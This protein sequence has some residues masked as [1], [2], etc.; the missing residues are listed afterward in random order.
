VFTGNLNKRNVHSSSTIDWMSPNY[1][2]DS[3]INTL[4]TRNVEFERTG[5][6]LNAK[7]VF[8]DKSELLADI[9]FINFGIDG[10]QL[11]RTQ[12][13]A[14]GSPVQITKGIIPSDLEILTAKIDYSR[15]FNNFFWEAGIKTASTKTD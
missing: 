9:D 4:G 1:E 2:I 14:M 15:R 10:D 12:L 7:H 11:F 6:N 13:S 5:V 8:P 3:T